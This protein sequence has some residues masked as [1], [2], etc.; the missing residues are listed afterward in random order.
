M[1]AAGIVAI[2]VIVT[3]IIDM[4]IKRKHERERAEETQRILNTPLP[5]NPLSTQG[6]WQTTSIT[7]NKNQSQ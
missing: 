6:N 5:N 1:A 4:V 7:D 2:L 3:I